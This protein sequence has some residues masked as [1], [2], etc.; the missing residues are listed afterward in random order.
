MNIYDLRPRDDDPGTIPDVGSKPRPPPE[1][2]P[3]APDASDWE[4]PPIPERWPEQRDMPAAADRELRKRN[5]ATAPAVVELDARGL[6]RVVFKHWGD[7]APEILS[8]ALDIAREARE[9]GG[10]P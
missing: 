4:D 3:D 9:T 2:A 1:R 7:Q 10:R 5:G 8:R 6:A